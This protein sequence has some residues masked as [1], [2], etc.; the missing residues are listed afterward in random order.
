MMPRKTIYYSDPLNDE[1][2]GVGKRPKMN[3]NG[4]YRY[5]NN[6]YI[7]RAA[8]FFIYRIIMTPIAFLYCYLKF[9]MKCVGLDK[10]KK[11]RKTGYYLYGNHTQI[12]GDGFIPNVIAYPNKVYLIVNPDNV[13]APGTRNI[14]MMLGC[15]PVPT[16]FGG[17]RNFLGAIEKRLD[18]G[19]CV[20]IYPE[21]HIWPYYTGIR[22]FPSLS[23]RYPANDSRPVFTF[24]VT[25]RQSKHGH[26]RIVAFI[27]GPFKSDAVT[28]REREK[29]LRDMAFIAMC[30]RAKKD[31]YEFVKYVYMG[32]DTK[33]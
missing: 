30:G 28:P 11:Y 3:I 20:V 22:P 31:N 17:F 26:P 8:A 29:E 21:A 25:Y 10:L 33:K 4:S 1:F 6:N 23:F 12:P 15:L 16:E 14:M 32:G 5:I 13:A 7:F 27:D 9:G 2:S 19:A 24:T 18:E